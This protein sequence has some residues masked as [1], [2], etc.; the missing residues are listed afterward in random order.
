M[1]PLRSPHARAFVIVGAIGGIIAAFGG[2]LALLFFAAMAAVFA[3]GTHARASHLRC[4]GCGASQRVTT[5]ADAATL[6]NFRWL[7][8]ACLAFGVLAIVALIR[9]VL[10]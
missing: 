1:T 4:S 3:G 2:A 5:D 10:H 7:A 8:R 9:H 6:R